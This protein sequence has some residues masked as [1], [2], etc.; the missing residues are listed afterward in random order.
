MRLLPLTLL[1]MTFWRTCTSDDVV[2]SERSCNIFEYCKKTSLEN[3]INGNLQLFHT[4]KVRKFN[5]PII[6]TSS[7][8]KKPGNSS[9]RNNENANMGK[10]DGVLFS[11][12]EGV[13]IVTR[14]Y[15]QD[16][17]ALAS[18]KPSKILH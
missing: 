6:L 3:S 13:L 15:S 7:I 5:Q 10:F 1:F 14:G 11:Y 2:K 12:D 17:L 8:N 9:F 4:K 16:L 18:E